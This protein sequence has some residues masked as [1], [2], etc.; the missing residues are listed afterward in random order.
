[1]T[2]PQQ[3]PAGHRPAASVLA[4][5]DVCTAARFRLRPR[6]RAAM[7][8]DDVWR[9]DDVDG[10]SV[11]MSKTSWTRLD[12]TA[13]TDPRWRLAAKEYLFARLAPGHPEIA[14]LPRAFRVP[15]TLATCAKRLA[16]T[17][18]WM[19]WLTAQHVPSLGDVTQDHCDRYLAGRCLRRDAAGTVI[20]TMEAS[21]TRVAAPS[22]PNWPSTAN[23]CPPTVTATG[24]PPGTADRP[25]RSPECG[26]PRRTRRPSSAKNSSSRC[27]Q[28]RST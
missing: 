16:E 8:D 10:L 27:W 23:C 19:N 9:F 15:L 3:A 14:V 24:S 17:I 2:A 11:Q 6:G 12:F 25:R 22:S 4:G 20:G 28:P 1:M 5:A 18:R 13:I 21:G 26:R 7:F